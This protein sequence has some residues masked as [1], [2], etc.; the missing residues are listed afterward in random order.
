MRVVSHI[1][2]GRPAADVFAYDS[3]QT[4][5]PEWQQGLHE[6]RRVTDHPIGVGTKHTFVRR[7]GRRQIS[8]ENEY[9][10]FEPG[11]R[12]LFTF[13]SDDLDLTGRGWYEASELGTDHTRLESGVEID[14]RGLIRLASPLAAMG[15]RK[16]DSQDSAR[17][18]EILEKSNMATK[19]SRQ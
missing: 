2:I 19:E 11:R 14:L 4:N 5:R 15:I 8:G 12:V 10:E 7:L 17:L 3:D 1:D 16:E 13:T 6:V 18:K 9:L